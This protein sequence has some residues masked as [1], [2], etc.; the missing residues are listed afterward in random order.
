[1]P[2]VQV[3]VRIP[4]EMVR[5]IDRLMAEGGFT[6]RSNAIKTIVAFYRE[7]ERTRSFHQLL[8]ERSREARQKPK[9]LIPL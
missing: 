1:M 8:L 3:Q 2:T 4:E 7:R 6:S 5:E 9:R